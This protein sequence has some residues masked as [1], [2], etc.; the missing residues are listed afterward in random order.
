MLVVADINQTVNI[1]IGPAFS[2]ITE[3]P[4]TDTYDI[5]CFLKIIYEADKI[6]G[7]TVGLESDGKG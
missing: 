6:G 2:G 7:G 1:R 5:F 4:D 3:R